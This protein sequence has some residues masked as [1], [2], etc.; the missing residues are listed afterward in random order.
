M[1]ET[2]KMYDPPSP[3]EIIQRVYLKPYNISG[4]ELATKLK[5]SPSTV[6]RLLKAEIG[7]SAD[8]ALRISAVLGRSPGS[9]MNMQKIYALWQAEQSFDA[10]ELERIDF[11]L[12]KR[13]ED[14]D[15]DLDEVERISGLPVE[16]A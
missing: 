13:I 6:S 4:R 12:L 2:L 8:M 3:G 15:I 5:V 10:S 16:V 14:K 1:E 9:W 7:L 11:S